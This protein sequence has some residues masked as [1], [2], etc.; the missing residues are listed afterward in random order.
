MKN[1][2]RGYPITVYLQNQNVEKFSH[3]VVID[4]DQHAM[5]LVSLYI[6]PNKQ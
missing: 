3:E 4:V 6:F 5:S 2:I 1:V